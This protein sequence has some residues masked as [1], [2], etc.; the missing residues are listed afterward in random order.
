MTISGVTTCLW[1]DDQA[2]EA[3]NFYAS[4]FPGASILSV[5]RYATDAQKPEGSVL[6]VEFELFGQP[7]LALNGGPHFTHSPAIS[8][9]VF[10]DT[11]DEVDR[12]WDALVSDG[13]EESMC[14]WCS[15]RFGVSWQIIPRRLTE[16]L[17]SPD[18]GV[19]R[20]TTERMMGMRKIVIADL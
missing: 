6:T 17:S 8:F 14:G 1:F 13:G 9:Q 15:D 19:A 11:Q 3:A 20:Q 2:E 12:L 4:V 10:C 16:L 5:S 7:F 18:P